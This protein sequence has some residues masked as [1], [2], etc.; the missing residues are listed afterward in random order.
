MCFYPFGYG[1]SYTSFRYSDLQV[2]DGEKEMNAS[3][4]LK[5][6]GKYA[7][8]EIAQ[9]YL[10]LPEKSELMPL[11]ELKGFERIFGESGETRRTTIRL[12]KDLLRYWDEEKEDFVYPSGNY[13]IMVGTSSSDIRLRKISSIIHK[14][15]NYI[16]YTKR[17]N[18]IVLNFI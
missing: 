5:N 7:G 13:T 1:L 10:E 4:H 12:W 17:I 6:V 8:D 15:N 2:T 9:V 11:K 16:F 18:E 14:Y 3:F